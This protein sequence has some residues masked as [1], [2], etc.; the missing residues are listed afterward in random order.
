[1]ESTEYLNHSNSDYIDSVYES[2]IKDPHSV[3][4]SWRFFFDG[5]E[6]GK[7]FV[8]PDSQGKVISNGVVKTKS[9]EEIDLRLEDKVAHLINAYRERGCWLADLNPIADAPGDH[10]LLKLEYFGLSS[11]DLEKNFVA[12]KAIGLEKAKLKDIWQKLKRTYC[13]T[14]SFDF[15]H[16]K[17]HPIRDWL[18]QKMEGPANHESLAADE[19]KLIHKRLVESESFE[20]FLAARYVAQKRFS[21]EGGEVLIP[22]LDRICAISAALG[23]EQVVMGMA[24]RGRLNVLTNVFGKDYEYIFTEFEQSY[25]PDQSMGE[26]DV[27]YHMGYSSDVRTLSGD[28][29]HLT[30]ANNPSH[31]E[32]VNPV[33]EGI[34]KAK[35]KL[36]FGADCSKVLPLLIHGDAAFAGQGVVYET[37]N[38]SKVDG[39]DTGGSIHIVVNN[40]VGFTTGPESARS[41]EFCTDIAHMLG[42]PVFHVNGDDPEAVYLA[43]KLSAEFRAQFKKDVVIDIICYRKHGHNEGDEPRYTQP[44]MYDKIKKHKSVRELYQQKLIDEGHL[45]QEEA[46][47]LLKRVKEKLTKA[48]EYT[49]EKK[50][51]PKIAAYEKNWK[52][53]KRFD[54]SRIF[55]KIVTSV[56]EEQLLALGNKLC[57]LPKNF[58]LF[59][60]LN[61]FLDGRR[62]AL[63]KKTG[64]DWGGGEALAYATLLCDGHNVRLSGQDVCRG[65]FS[66]RHAVFFDAKTAAPYV[67]LQHIAEGQSEFEV[68]NSTLSEAGVLGFEYGWSLVNPEALNIWEA[69]FGDFCNGAQVIIDQFIT[70]GESKWQRASGLVMYLPHGY[71]GQ[72]PEHSSARPERFLQMCGRYNIFVCNLTTPAQLFHA[73]RRQV[74]SNYRKPL[75]ILTPKSLLRH[76]KAISDLSDFS[77]YYFEEILDDPFF[78]EDKTLKQKVRR[79]LIC[80]GKIY[81]DLLKEREEL[82]RDDVA[83]LRLEQLYPFPESKILKMIDSYYPE[84]EL[85][86]VQEEP[87]NMGAW[88]FVNNYWSGGYKDLAQNLENPRVLK[89]LGRERGAASSVGSMKGHLKEQSRIVKEAFEFKLS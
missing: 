3:D 17:D 64:I 86:W 27:K 6:V 26:G 43:A 44:L 70:S 74:K 41:T 89:Y 83:L 38:F 36:F 67:P 24:H 73:L 53:I 32:S 33:V 79:V 39:Y 78:L 16:I 59:P 85:F 56:D 34:A 66:H 1:M 82:K 15:S 40:Q 31:L 48:L 62:E 14:L 21:I 11:A 49:R 9:G 5:L 55:E 30:L 28:K 61:R 4:E 29:L 69:Q 77:Q 54:E 45:K 50:P 88:T 57:E 58:N 84:A 8:V 80:S 10:P 87:R 81:Y 60:K 35:Q 13:E 65:T 19:K 75:V 63:S 71:E 47:E 46:D 51:R 68:F 76:P 72:G 23:V 22:A 7:D 12:G 37:L 20:R 52:H 25:E 42:V 18:R 2:Y